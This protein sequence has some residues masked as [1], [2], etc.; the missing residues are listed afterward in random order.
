MTHNKIVIQ[1]DNNKITSPKEKTTDKTFDKTLR[2]KT[3]GHFIGQEKIKENL[4]IAIK[5][6]SKRKEPIEHILFYGPPGLG[7]TTLANIVS[8]ELGVNI[9]T[10]SGP[11]IERAGDLASILTNV[12]ENDVL[13]IDEIHR[14]NKM[15]E[16][17]LYPAMEESA[18]DIV[19]GKGPSAKSL[20]LEIPKCT[21]VGAT[22]RLGLLS[23]PLRDRFGMTHHLD[24]YNDED[25]QKIIE[26]SASALK[27][28]MSSGAARALSKSSRKTPRIANRLLRR[29]RDFA[30]VNDKEKIDEQLTKDSLKMLAIDEI[31][32]DD[33]DRK[34]LNTIIEKFAGGPVGISTLAA[35]TGEEIDTIEE[36]VEPFLMQIGFLKRTP[37]GRE[38]TEHAYKHLGI[39][40]KGKLF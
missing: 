14:L 26:Q 3:F 36:V 35:S 25:I 7:K 32:L 27:I 33:V 31:G 37:K 18:I 11:A 10:T 34:I 12:Q 4:K 28:N 24:F 39:T 5:A 22:T 6:A 40:T 9:K 8:N 17:I 20:R 16:E 38:V 13:F 29:T 15:V 1:K 21:I 30:S 2:P 19:I 23:S